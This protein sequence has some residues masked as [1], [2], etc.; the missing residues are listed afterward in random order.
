MAAC[1]PAGK[2]NNLNGCQTSFGGTPWT[3]N[4]SGVSSANHD[5]TATVTQTVMSKS[6]PITGYSQ[7]APAGQEITFSIT[8]DSDLGDYGSIQLEAMP[9]NVPTG[10]NVYAALVYL[11]DGTNDLINLPRGA[12]SCGTAGYYTSTGINASC[13]PAW[14]SAYFDRNQ[15]EYR[16]DKPSVNTFPTC[17][18]SGGSAPSSTDS[19]CAFN[20]TF[21]SGGKLRYGANWTAKYVLIDFNHSSVS[22]QTA[23]LKLNIVKKTD[24]GSGGALDLNV[25][26]VGDK[27]VEASRS[28]AGKRN[29]DTLFNEVHSL[30]SQVGV[31]LGTINVFEWPCAAGGDAYSNISLSKMG[32]LFKTGGAMLPS[33]V[34]GKAVNIFAIST[35]T[36]SPGTVG[37]AGAIGGPLPKG[38]GSSGTIVATLD[39]LGSENAS[40]SSTPCAKTTWDEDYYYVPP[41]FA[42]EMGHYLGLNHPSEKGAVAHDVLYDTP[43]CTNGGVVSLSSC[44]SDTNVSYMT[45]QTCASVCSGRSSSGG[46]CPTK[47]ECQF[48]HLMF[49]TT[50]YFVVGTGDGDGNLMT[51]QTGVVVNYNPLI[52]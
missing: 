26:L 27:N 18:W 16:I 8:M 13:T 7:A 11:N 4:I 37:I 39:K 52:Q 34:D 28:A 15:W 33:S 23:T 49:R 2:T 25:I 41:A 51:T 44:Q 24:T 20:S 3:P 50:K 42:H 21:F 12:G 43:I 32:D 36:D 10:Y 14:P 1:G 31:K 30:Y 40:C 5:G 29:L 6:G 46:F 22:S 19:A 9:L 17:N 48:N 47:S 35:F 45:G 38:M